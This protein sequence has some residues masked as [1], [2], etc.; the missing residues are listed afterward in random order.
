[1]MA[2]KTGQRSLLTVVKTNLEDVRVLSCLKILAILGTDLGRAITASQSEV[3]G[4][5]ELLIVQDANY[6]LH[7]ADDL[8]KEMLKPADELKDD[9]EY[10]KIQEEIRQL[11]K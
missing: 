6:T 9:V 5:K 7:G 2:E 8:C 4:M 11:V 10:S 3:F 1:M